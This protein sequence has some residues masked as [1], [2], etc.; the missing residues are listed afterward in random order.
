MTYQNGNILNLLIV[1][2]KYLFTAV[3]PLGGRG[4][5]KLTNGLSDR[6]VTSHPSTSCESSGF[7]SEG[8]E[9]LSTKEATK[10]HLIQSRLE[11]M[12]PAG[13]IT[14][15]HLYALVTRIPNNPLPY[16]NLF[17]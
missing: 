3:R 2:H 17:C 4:L 12:T 14:Y 5:V 7:S 16:T 10:H 6:S 1:L 11:M 13:H 9:Y 8:R 15:T